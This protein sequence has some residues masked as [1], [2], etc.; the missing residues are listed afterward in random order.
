M[1]GSKRR[2][3]AQRIAARRQRTAGALAA[4]AL[5]RIEGVKD[6]AAIEDVS[7]FTPATRQL[8]LHLG[9]FADVVR[10]HRSDRRTHTHLVAWRPTRA[11]AMAIATKRAAAL[12]QS[13]R[14][15]AIATRL[16]ERARG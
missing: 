13:A 10:H 14:I 2:S 8:P 12:T 7:T 6:A 5:E 9:Y 1:T 15:N 3:P 11:G 16:A 4:R